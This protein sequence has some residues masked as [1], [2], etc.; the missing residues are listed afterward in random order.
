MI[1]NLDIIRK[2]LGLKFDANT[3][4]VLA[5]IKKEPLLNIKLEIKFILN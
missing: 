5:L 4:T 2:F 3:E 1:I